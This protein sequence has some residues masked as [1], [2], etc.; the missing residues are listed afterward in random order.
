MESINPL[1]M[2]VCHRYGV[3]SWHTVYEHIERKE[4]TYIRAWVPDAYLQIDRPIS[5]YHFHLGV[6]DSHNTHAWCSMVRTYVCMYTMRVFP[7][8][9]CIYTFRMKCTY[10]CI[11][12]CISYVFSSV[13]IDGYIHFIC[14]YISIYISYVFW[15][16]C[17]MQ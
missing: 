2:W 5:V 3:S 4:Y 12:I 6:R 17:M 8:T 7:R 13:Y 1:Y 11:Y 9:I 14:I 16:T 10:T 15:R